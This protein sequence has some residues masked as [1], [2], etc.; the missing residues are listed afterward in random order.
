MCGWHGRLGCAVGMGGWDVRLAWVLG[1]CGWMRHL[2]VGVLKESEVFANPCP[3][4]KN[5]NSTPF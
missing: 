4:A 1:V 2:D 5:S 3:S